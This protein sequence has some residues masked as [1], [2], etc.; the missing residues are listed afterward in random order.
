MTMAQQE[1][2][3]TYM[4]E[5]AEERI[6]QSQKNRHPQRGPRKSKD[7]SGSSWSGDCGHA[8]EAGGLGRGG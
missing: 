7:H 1:D 4:D 2:H 8:G 5:T 6:T 3:E